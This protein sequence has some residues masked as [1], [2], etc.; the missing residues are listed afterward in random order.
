MR[1]IRQDLEARFEQLGKEVRQFID[2]ITPESECATFY[3]DVDHVEDEQLIRI[4]IDLPG[5]DKN[6]IHLSIK[7]HVLTIKGE[8]FILYPETIKKHRL[9]RNNGLFTRSFA[10]P[11]GLNVADIK[12]KFKDG[13]LM[14]EIPRSEST[15][16]VNKI[17]IE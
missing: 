15:E 8:R 5:M 2:R 6:D 16:E 13:V 11:S 3:P 12:A 9:E 17:I 10:V 1:D 4:F 14:I 7:D